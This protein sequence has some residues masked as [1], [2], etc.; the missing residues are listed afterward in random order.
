MTLL[1]L[2]QL[3]MSHGSDFPIIWVLFISSHFYTS[4]VLKNKSSDSLEKNS[5]NRPQ[6]VKFV[7]VCL[8]L[9]VVTQALV[10]LML[11]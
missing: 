6:A 10:D 11:N 2:L 8:F 5:T 9:R 7:V 4:K 3:F 1:L